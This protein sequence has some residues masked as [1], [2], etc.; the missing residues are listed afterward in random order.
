LLA[1]YLLFASALDLWEGL[2]AH[3]GLT[4][5]S[6]AFGFYGIT[7]FIGWR[8]AYLDLRDGLA[9]RWR[10]IPPSLLPR[11]MPKT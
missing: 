3:A 5:V 4:I 6:A 2:Y 1:G 11:P 9:R 10:T 8:E 7:Y